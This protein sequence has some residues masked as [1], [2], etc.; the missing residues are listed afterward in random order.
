[1]NGL[2]MSFWAFL[3]LFFKYPEYRGLVDYRLKSSKLF[4]PLR[5]IIY[6]SYKSHNLWLI[7]KH[8]IEGGLFLQHGFSTIVFCESMG[9]NC[10][11]N[12][13]VTIGYDGSSGIPTIGNNVRVSCGAKVLGKITIGDDVYIGANAVVVKDVPSHSMVVGVPAKI[14]KKRD[15]INEKWKKI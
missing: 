3:F 11:I 2:K 15:N 6:F 7:S 13:Q 12:Q 9:N 1:M 8:G 4:I 5:I 10:F 14:I